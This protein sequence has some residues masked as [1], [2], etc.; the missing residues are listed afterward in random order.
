M[1]IFDRFRLDGKVAI[2]TGASH[3]IG[4]GIALALAQAG[5]DVVCAARTRETLETVATQIRALGRRALVVP[6][7]VMQSE[8]LENLVHSARKELGRI[9]IAVNNAGGGLY[10]PALHTSESEFEAM[11]RF[12]LVSAFSLTRLVVPHMLEVGGGNILN[13]SSV[14]GHLCERGFVTYSTAK[15][16]LSHLTRVL[17]FEF[18]PK[19]RVNA[20]AA[21]SVDTPALA[22]F[23]IDTKMRDKMIEATPMKRIGTTEDIALAALYL[24]SAASSWVTGKVF[25]IDGGALDSNFPIK[26]ADL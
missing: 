18:A 22:P 20:I 13:I 2:V 3:G 15:A 16:G 9:D 24:T 17:A 11:L 14:L 23:L 10:K 5:A 21:G 25:E 8:Q 4:E 26:M 12:N 6:C 19:V 1:P 7:D